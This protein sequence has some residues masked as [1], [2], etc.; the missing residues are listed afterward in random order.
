MVKWREVHKRTVERVTALIMRH[1]TSQDGQDTLCVC[2]RVCVR[3][4]AHVCVRVCMHASVC[5]CACVSV[6]VLCVRVCVCVCVC[7][8]VT[9]TVNWCRLL[10]LEMC[11]LYSGLPECC[12]GWGQGEKGGRHRG[13]RVREDG[14]GNPPC[15]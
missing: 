1:D 7:V 9:L 3:T 12:C 8:C 14:G 15:A 6:R 5:V 11:T 4:R 10:L 13:A 2:V